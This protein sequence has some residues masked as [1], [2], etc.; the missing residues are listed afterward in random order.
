MHLFGLVEDV[1]QVAATTVLTVVHSGHEDTSAAL[2][3]RA[4]T[5]KA[6]D[7]AITIDLVV[8]QDS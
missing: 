5:A 7:L 2:G 1:C 3:L 8:L 4:L 6:L